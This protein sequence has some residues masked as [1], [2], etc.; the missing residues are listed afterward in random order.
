MMEVI[1]WFDQTGTGIVQRYPEGGSGDI[2]M[3]AQLIVRE[4]QGAVFFRDGKGLDIFGPGRHTLTTQNLPI[5][6]RLL[7]LPWGFTEPVPRRGLL[8]Q[9][10]GLHRHAVGHARAGGLQGQPS[11]A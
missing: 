1:E 7:S 8:R 10:E 5:L 11:S 9:P 3:G 6:T 4:N 2:K